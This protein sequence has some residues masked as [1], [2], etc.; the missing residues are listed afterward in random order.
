MN[1]GDVLYFSDFG[2]DDGGHAKKLL[3]VISDPAKNAVVMLITTSKGKQK[4]LG[5]QATAKKF[6]IQAKTH[7]FPSDTWFDLARNAI[8]R[9]TTTV[10][11]AV[12]YPRQSRGLESLEPLKAV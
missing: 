9:D 11:T 7:G 5:C 10:T 8:V 6:F 4:D 1:V 3:L 12:M 2:F